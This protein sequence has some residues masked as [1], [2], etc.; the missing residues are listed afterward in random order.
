M[1]QNK[2]YTREGMA[3]VTLRF[4]AIRQPGLMELPVMIVR[5]SNCYGCLRKGFRLLRWPGAGIPKIRPNS[6][7]VGYLAQSSH[8][9]LDRR[10]TV[11][12]YRSRFL[13]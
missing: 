8:L 5:S 12:P 6:P 2:C 3:S 9:E 10:G 13:S 11:C 4:G 1:R 7:L